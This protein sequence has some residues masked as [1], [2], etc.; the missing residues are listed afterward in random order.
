MNRF[1]T[2][3][4]IG[5]EEAAFL[6]RLDGQPVHTPARHPLALPTACLARAVAEEWD[7]QGRSIEPATMPLTRLATTVVDLMP[8][9]HGD[10]VAEAAGFAAT[11]LLCYRADEPPLL[12]ER[13]HRLWQPW[14]DWALTRYDAPLVATAGVG[15]IPQPERALRSLRD[16]VVRLDPWRLVG[17]HAA[18]TLTGS[19]VLGLAVEQGAIDA[20]TAFRAAFLDELFEVERW[21]LDEEQQHRHAGLRRDLYAAVRFLGTLEPAEPDPAR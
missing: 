6:V 2:D 21:G 5:P 4:D 18:T 8:T 11:D 20:D 7:A 1:F 10:A 16:A 14:L 19:L 13:Q 9:R 17:V 12:V 3:V 15:P